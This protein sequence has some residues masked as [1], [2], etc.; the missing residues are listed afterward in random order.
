[1]DIFKEANLAGIKV[2]NR[3]IRSAT[4][5]KIAVP[6]EE[7]KNIYL[8]LAK[9]GVGAIITGFA[10]V[11][12]Q[13]KATP[14]MPM[15]CSPADY[16]SWEKLLQEVKRYET[17]V[18]L[19]LGHGGGKSTVSLIGRN[20]LAPSR[21]EYNRGQLSDELKA[22]EIKEI[23]RSYAD[24]IENAKKS[25]FDGVQIQAA[26]GFLLSEFLSPR[27]NQR[28]DEWGG[29]TENR[30]RIIQKIFFE[31]RQRVGAYPILV[32]LTAF[33]SE[34]GGMRVE[35]SIKIAKL[36][37]EASCDAIEV[38]CGNENI[39]ET[40]RPP[41]VPAEALLAGQ[42]NFQALTPEQKQ[43]AAQEITAKIKIPKP[44]ED[45]NVSAAAAIKSVLKI[46]VIVSGGIRKISKMREIIEDGKADFVALCRPFIIEPDL[47]DKMRAGKQ[48]ISRCINCAYCLALRHNTLKCHYGKAPQ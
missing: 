39:F 29:S 37:E 30:F 10:G 9:G 35:E 15:F 24:C 23:I 41:R 19:Q 25:G 20:G 3:I 44:L 31:A 33:D 17:P 47:V 16:G 26:H 1:M 43:L 12:P 22:E 7:L 27:L 21:Y 36:L 34:E 48:D 11:H 42:P 2:K 32:K 6:N 46:P 28:T 4:H 18:I 40:V 38:S 13:G 5:E 45:Y 8:R 14:Q